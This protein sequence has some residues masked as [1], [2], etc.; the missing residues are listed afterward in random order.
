MQYVD[1]GQ[2]MSHTNED[3]EFCDDE[4]DDFGDTHDTQCEQG[5]V[6]AYPWNI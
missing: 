4:E 6:Q 3:S 2:S 5:S 1:I